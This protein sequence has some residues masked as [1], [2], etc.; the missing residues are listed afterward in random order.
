M[1]KTLI[2]DFGDVFINLNKEATLIEMQKL[3]ITSFT[4]EMLQI[5]IQYEIGK[6][7]TETFLASY[8]ELFPDYTREQLSKAWNAIILDFPENR[9]KFIES[10]SKSK[11]FNLILLSNTNVLH[12]EKVIENM[13]L[14]RFN[15]FKNCFDAFY[16]SQEIHLR[17][18]NSDIYN[19]VIEKHNLKPSECLFIDDTKENTE[20]ANKLG[21]HT[22]NINPKTE[23]ILDL[24]S[25]KKELLYF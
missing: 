18:P 14:E 6:I 23:D 21:I 11:K 20:T 22:W 19:F 13:T 3:G 16:L 4:K 9:L 17:K 10:L 8:V 25:L 24:F 5:N 2:F 12:I 1:I 15:R 7:N